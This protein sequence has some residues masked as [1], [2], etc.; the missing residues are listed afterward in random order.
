MSFHYLE[1]G[2]YTLM[3]FGQFWSLYVYVDQRLDFDYAHHTTTVIELLLEMLVCDICQF[4]H[5]LAE[6]H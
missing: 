3:N 5:I 1:I 6:R 4:Y 2:K